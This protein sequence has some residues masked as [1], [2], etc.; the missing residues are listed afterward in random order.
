[1]V[2]IAMATVEMVDNYS[3]NIVNSYLLARSVEVVSD[4]GSKP[5]FSKA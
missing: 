2:V 3:A 5:A 4:I 1:M